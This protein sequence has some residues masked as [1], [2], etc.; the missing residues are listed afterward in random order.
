MGLGQYN[1]SVLEVAAARVG[2]ELRW[3]DK[4]VAFKGPV[5]ADVEAV[6][7][8]RSSFFSRH[9]FAVRRVHGVW[10]NLDSKLSEP[11]LLGEEAAAVKL[12]NEQLKD[13]AEL[14]QLVVSSKG[15]QSDRAADS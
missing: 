1:I 2:R 12:L 4:R 15:P 6:L 11:V 9:W 8:N 7:V 3:H 10:Y 5:G 14:I 13:G